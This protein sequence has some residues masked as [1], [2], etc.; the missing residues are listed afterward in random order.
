MNAL[1][2][3]IAA[4]I[5]EDGPISVERYMT[6][7]LQHPRYGYYRTR[8]PL[9]VHGDFTTAPEIHQMFGEL[10][11]L[12]AV[13]VWQQ[14]DQPPQFKLIELGPGRGTLMSDMLRAAKV[15]PA[16]LRAAA[17]HLVETSEA[18]ADLQ[19]KTLSGFA[20]AWHAAIGEVPEGPAIIIANEFFDALPIRQFVQTETGLCERVIGLDQKGELCFGLA[21]IGPSAQHPSAVQGSVL[22]V[23]TAAQAVMHAVA[24]RLARSSGVLLAIDYGYSSQSAGD[25]LQAAK[26][27]AFDDPLRAPGEADLTSHVDFGALARAATVAGA[28]VFGPVTQGKFLGRLGIFERAAALKRNAMV[29]QSAAVDAALA[30]LALP[31]P[32]A[33]P[34]A[35]MADLF[36]VLAVTSADLPAPPGFDADTGTD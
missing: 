35:S 27:H 17:I 13:E 14:M 26:N 24:E 9:G 3:E 11:G 34:G 1:A 23:G 22:E 6:L 28:H 7:A 12:W 32:A 5:A 18:L 31:G 36:K 8:L 33:G 30:R 16:F 10:I 15:R 2:K 21:P 19:R 29:S 25:T 20:I 4:M